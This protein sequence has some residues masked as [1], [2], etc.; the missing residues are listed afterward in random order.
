MHPIAHML[1]IDVT[2]RKDPHADVLLVLGGNR[3]RS[4]YLTTRIPIQQVASATAHEGLFADQLH[5][6]VLPPA[7]LVISV[8]RCANRGGPNPRHRATPVNARR[9]QDVGELVIHLKGLDSGLQAAGFRHFSAEQ[10][11][12][13]NPDI[14]QDP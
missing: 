13:H 9:V 12:H 8:C 1:P 3:C 2:H 4:R 10:P 7:G 6:L 14:L 5:N 11:N